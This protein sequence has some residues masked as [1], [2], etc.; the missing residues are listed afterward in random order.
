MVECVP[1]IPTPRRQEDLK[2]NS[3]HPQVYNEFE[4]Y[5]GYIN[6]CLK[7]KVPIFQLSKSFHFSG[8]LYVCLSH[9][10]S[11]H[12]MI[13]SLIHCVPVIVDMRLHKA[14]NKRSKVLGSC[15][16]IPYIPV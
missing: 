6:Y 1:V 9:L 5:L 11:P 12:K 3:S 16:S 14:V 15:S 13:Y 4:A 10:L 7:Y 2:F 8:S